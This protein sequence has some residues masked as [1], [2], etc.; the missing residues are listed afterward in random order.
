MLKLE[1]TVVYHESSKLY[2]GTYAQKGYT[3]SFL[4]EWL[5][6]KDNNTSCLDN[7]SREVVSKCFEREASSEFFSVNERAADTKRVIHLALTSRYQS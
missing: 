3:W 5:S 4:L 6:R 1:A 7:W 2:D